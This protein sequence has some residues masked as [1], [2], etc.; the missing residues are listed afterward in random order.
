[1]LSSLG[2][3][4]WIKRF[5]VDSLQIYFAASLEIQEELI[6]HEFFVPKS[7]KREI[8][9]PIPLIYSNF[10]GWIK[11]KNPITMERLIPPEWFGYTPQQLHWREIRGDNKKAYEIPDE[12]VYVNIGVLNSK[13]VFDLDII[14]YHLERTSIR[15]INPEKWVNW[16]MFYISI[17]YIDELIDLLSNYLSRTKQEVFK[18]LIREIQQN[19]KEITY[20]AQVPV[21]DFSFCLGCFDLGLQYIYAKAIEHCQVKPSLVMC[22]NI[23][24]T[25]DSLKLRLKYNFSINTFA[26]VGIAKISG[27]RPQIM[28][29]LASTGPIKTIQGILKPQIEGKARGELVYCDH[30]DRRQYVALSLNHF[31]TALVTSKSYIDRLS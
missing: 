6:R 23:K 8:I 30:K 29:K 17:E 16:I 15:G 2:R 22:R 25:V 27:K 18:S 9:M 20:Y 7:S 13:L 4:T 31:Y 3:V 26:K 10:Q 21:E 14:R 11:H 5:P 1:M 19:G 28:I 12:E 24:E